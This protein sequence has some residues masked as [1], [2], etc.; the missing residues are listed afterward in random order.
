MGLLAGAG[1]MYLLDPVNGRRR[2]AMIRDKFVRIGHV[3]GRKAGATA[4]DVGNRLKG[5]AAQARGLSKP[6]TDDVLAQRIRA[7]LGRLVK[8]PGAVEV[9]VEQ[10]QVE[11]IGTLPALEA[12]RLV[13]AVGRLRGVRNVQNR[14]DIAAGSEERVS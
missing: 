9:S 7:R 6:L 3:A 11:L 8:D 2:R 10:G 12:E 1:L 14:L 4:R 13:H 5:V